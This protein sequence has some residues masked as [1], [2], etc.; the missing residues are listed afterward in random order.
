MDNADSSFDSNF[1]RKIASEFTS[2]NVK[3]YLLAISSLGQ[4]MQ[5]DMNIYFTRDI[6]NEVSF[7]RKLYLIT[8]NVIHGLNPFELVLMLSTFGMQ[9]LL[10]G[11]RIREID[12]GRKDLADNIVNKTSNSIDFEIELRLQVLE[13][14]NGSNGNNNNGAYITTA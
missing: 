2:K 5:E 4:Q 10:I 12:I 14:N 8:K 3:N 7:R 1:Q 13:K 11:S 9:N 6:L